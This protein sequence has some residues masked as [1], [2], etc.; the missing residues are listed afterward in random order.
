MSKKEDPFNNAF[1]ALKALKKEE[2]KTSGK[3]K[4]APLPPP[5]PKK[6]NSDE[7]DAML[8]LE[9]IGEVAPVKQKIE[10]VAPTLPR[11][12]DQLRIPTEEAESLARLAELVSGDTE[13]DLSDSDEFIEGS[14]VG[15]DARV[16]RKLRTGDFSTQANIDLHG[17][18][19]EE[20]KLALE[21]FIQ[22]ARVSGYRCVLV[23]TGRGL[24]SKDSI[25]VLKQS[26]QGWLTR[27]KVAKQVLAF[28]SANPK[29]GGTG[30]LYVLLRR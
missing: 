17:L 30:A 13:F 10:R 6:P 3:A 18:V 26:V 27:G 19:R 25:P 15:F 21:T 24:H 22:K 1:G 7:D 5:K 28:C 4:P 12:A 29:D 8:F 11:S 16:M 23:V 20:A 14:I 9:S 2:P